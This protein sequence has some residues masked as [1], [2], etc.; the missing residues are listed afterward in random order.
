[1]SEVPRSFNVKLLKRSVRLAGHP[2]SLSLEEDFWDILE[3]AAEAD[4]ISLAQ[5]LN[6]I[7]QKRDGPM[8]S[9]SRVFA[10]R[11]LLEEVEHLRSRS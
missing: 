10:L 8:A 5:L 6:D 11:R 9:A 2:T 1:M 4:D 7:D 3:A